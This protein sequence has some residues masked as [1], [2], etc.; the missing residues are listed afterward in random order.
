MLVNLSFPWR[1][2]FLD[3]TQTFGLEVYVSENELFRY[4]DENENRQ[5]V[6][7]MKIYN[8]RFKILINIVWHN[9]NILKLIFWF[10]IVII[11]HFNVLNVHFNNL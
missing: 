10:I 2:Y 7:G 8:N 9:Y 3:E 6:I 5:K 11:I 1:G 4:F